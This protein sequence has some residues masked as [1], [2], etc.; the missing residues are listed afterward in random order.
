M[1]MRERIKLIRKEKNLTQAEFAVRLGLAPTST[2]AWERKNNPQIPTESMQLLICEKFGVNREWLRTGTGS[3]FE[4]T[5]D[6]ELSA[7]AQAH[8]LD[9]MDVALIRTYISLPRGAQSALKDFLRRL[10]AA[11]PTP[12]S[13]AAPAI[14]REEMDAIA[15]RL[16]ALEE[17]AISSRDSPAP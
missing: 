3:P 13:S 4:P 11:A 14:T 17:S 9:E 7:L 15:D 2:S 5:L 8:G 10:A 1:E 6:D 12:P 16:D